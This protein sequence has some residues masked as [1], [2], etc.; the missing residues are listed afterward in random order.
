MSFYINKILLKFNQV[1][2]TL[3]VILQNILRC[4]DITLPMHAT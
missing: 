4:K 2:I 1:N 3:L